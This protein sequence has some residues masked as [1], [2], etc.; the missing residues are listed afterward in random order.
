MR[1]YS[2]NQLDTSANGIYDFRILQTRIKHCRSQNF[3]HVFRILNPT[4]PL[5][6]ASNLYLEANNYHK[7]HRV[8]SS[9]D[10]KHNDELW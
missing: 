1:R 7:V 8:L 4:D 9:S 2:L 3:M 5:A 10:K 6:S